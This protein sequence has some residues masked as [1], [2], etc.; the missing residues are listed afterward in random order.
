MTKINHLKL[1]VVFKVSKE[2]KGVVV[3]ARCRD[4]TSTAAVEAHKQ[5][6]DTTPVCSFHEVCPQLDVALAGLWSDYMIGAR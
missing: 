3:D 6:P 5:D 4:L 2:K 1:M